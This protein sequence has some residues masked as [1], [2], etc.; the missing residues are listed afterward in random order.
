MFLE[1]ATIVVNAAPPLAD[2]ASSDSAA[3]PSGCPSA[4][5][6]PRAESRLA[7][8]ARPAGG[9]SA[10]PRPGG[11]PAQTQN[12]CQAMCLNPARSRRRLW[13]LLED[14]HNLYGHACNA[15]AAPEVA[16]H[17]Q[18]RPRRRATAAAPAW[19]VKHRM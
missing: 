1:Q 9:P 5:M 2:P 12:W 4:L 15:D 3:G 18:A 14:W 19:P 8:Q 17:L 6:P 16:R 10:A 7:R 13:K 11:A